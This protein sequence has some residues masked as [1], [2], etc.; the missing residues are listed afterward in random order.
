MK[1]KSAALLHAMKR[2]K[3]LVKTG[4]FLSGISSK[5]MAPLDATMVHDKILTLKRVFFS[6]AFVNNGPV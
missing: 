2:S 4:N 5:L 6:R 1:L 3:S